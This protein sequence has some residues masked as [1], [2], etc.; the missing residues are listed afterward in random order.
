LRNAV[1]LC[2]F[3]DV[4]VSIAG[5]VP[6]LIC[7]D[8]KLSGA[9]RSIV[10]GDKLRI[11]WILVKMSTNPIYDPSGVISDPGA[12]AD[13]APGSNPLCVRSLNPKNNKSRKKSLE[14]LKSKTI[15]RRRACD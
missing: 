3:T 15:L 5:D 6:I 1:E 8:R 7:F 14:L 2:Q 9:R 12:D 11:V 10:D 4:C 13:V